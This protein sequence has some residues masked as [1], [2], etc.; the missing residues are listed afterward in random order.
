[1]I[2]LFFKRHGLIYNRASKS[3]ELIGIRDDL[4]SKG[5]I[6]ID[7]NKSLISVDLIASEAFLMM[8][9]IMKKSKQFNP[10]KKRLAI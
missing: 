2:R 4:N 3:F 6:C 5:Y 10:H 7:Y 1:M 9:K 8:D